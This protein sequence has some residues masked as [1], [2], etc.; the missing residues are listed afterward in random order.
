MKKPSVILLLLLCFVSH[1]FS[2]SE[3]ESDTSFIEKMMKEEEARESIDV[4]TE[5]ARPRRKR[6]SKGN[7]RRKR[8]N[9]EL[10]PSAQEA[11][12]P[13]DEV[14][15]I[16]EE[17][18]VPLPLKIRVMKSKKGKALIQ[19]SNKVKLPRG[20]RYDLTEPGGSAP[21]EISEA[22]VS[23]DESPTESTETVETVTAENE[24]DHLIGAS[25]NVG[26]FTQSTEGTAGE[27]ELKNFDL[28][29]SYGWN[30]GYVELAPLVEYNFTTSGTFDTSTILGGVFVD[31]N[32]IKN[33]SE[34]NVVIGLRLLGGFGIQDTSAQTAANSVI[35]I[36]PSLVLKWFSFSSSFAVLIQAGYRMDST[37]AS[38]TSVSTQGIVSQIGIQTYF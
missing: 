17:S 6:P 24:R 8:R 38:G 30:F 22:V 3:D 37:S 27:T 31:V 16:A 2:Y 13:S 32:F 11:V 28:S 23:E 5:P 20:K 26:L 15:G 25:L 14:L 1:D 29:L 33:E 4:D 36:Q 10:V 19:H 18:S 7:Q 34:N 35:R 21:A 12:D 9:I